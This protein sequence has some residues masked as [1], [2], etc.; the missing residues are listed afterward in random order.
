M[1]CRN[2]KH[3]Q[4]RHDTFYADDKVTLLSCCYGDGTTPMC[5]CTRYEEATPEDPIIADYQKYKDSFDGIKAR[6]KYLLEH[7][8]RLRELDNRSYQ[9]EYG[10]I[11]HTDHLELLHAFKILRKY[12]HV[13][14]DFETIRRAR[15]LLV[16]E[17]PELGPKNPKLI[18][19]K[20]QKK[21]AIEEC[22]TIG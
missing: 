13:I 7:I 22:V 12:Q 19:E 9:I 21:L 16:E 1:P 18:L 20:G 8:P 17:H 4:L 5:S 3:D 10:I 15:Q 6:H 11:H 14:D 2:C